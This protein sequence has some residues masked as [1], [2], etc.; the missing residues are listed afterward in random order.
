MGPGETD[1]GLWSLLLTDAGVQAIAT[2]AELRELRLGGTAITGRRHGT[3][4]APGQTRAAESAR[5]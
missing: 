4:E 3:A 2:V 5:L 1:S